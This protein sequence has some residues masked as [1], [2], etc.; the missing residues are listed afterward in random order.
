M[1]LSGTVEA[2]AYRG[3]NEATQPRGEEHT[4]NEA[5]TDDRADSKP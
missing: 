2:I 1:Y 4:G 3:Q 5:S